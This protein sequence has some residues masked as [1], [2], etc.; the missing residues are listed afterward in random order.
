MESLRARKR[1]G[2]AALDVY[3]LRKMNNADCI[4]S[5]EGAVPDFVLPAELVSNTINLSA[6]YRILSKVDCS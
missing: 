5:A 2:L 3:A 6:C 4:L 1:S